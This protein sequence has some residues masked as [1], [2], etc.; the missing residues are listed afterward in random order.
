MTQALKRISAR[1]LTTLSTQELWD[2][3]TGKFVVVFDDGEITTNDRETIYS[4]YAWEFHRQ[5]PE[6]PMLMKH[7]VQTVLKGRRLSSGTNLTLIGNVLH[8]TYFHYV[9]NKIVPG[10]MDD[11]DF[12]DVLAKMAY[13]VS[14]EM[15]ND[16]SDYLMEYVTSTN[17]LDFLE[18]LDDPDIHAINEE[19]QKIT[20]TFAIQQPER[21]EELIVANYAVIDSVLSDA[22]RFALNPISKAYKSGLLNKG[23]VH[24]CLG[25]RGYMTDI[26]SKMFAVP[27]TR[28]YVQGIR[29]LYEHMMESRSAAKSHT[30]SKSPLQ[31]AEYFSRRLQLM[32]QLVQNLHRGDCGSQMYQRWLVRPA[33]KRGKKT[34]FPADLPNLLGKYYLDEESGKLKAIT[35]DDTHLEGK[36]IR[37]RT[38][39]GCAHP[40]PYGICSTCFGQLS[41]GIPRETNIGQLCCTSLAQKSS[42]IVLSIKHLDGSATVEVIELDYEEQKYLIAGP[43]GNTYILSPTLKGKKIKLY[44]RPE[45]AV[46]IGDVHYT[47]DIDARPASRFTEIDNVIFHIGEAKGYHAQELEVMLGRRLASLTHDMLKYAKKHGWE[48]DEHGNCIIDLSEWD[49]TKPIMQLPLRHFNMSDHQR[50]IAD[51]LETSVGRVKARGEADVKAEELIIELF[52]LVNSKLKVN[53]AILEVVLY[54]T[55]CADP[56]NN[57]YGLSKPWTKQEMVTLM[58]AMENRSLGA[59]LAFQKHRDILTSPYSCLITNRPDHPFDAFV[60]PQAVLEGE[61]A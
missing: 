21:T 35:M 41:F 19:V 14:N 23:Q 59:V 16:F 38:P 55:T 52:D 8:D 17:I 61:H 11:V 1:F 22:K 31:Q 45:Q 26:D 40:D 47:E 3:L 43:G 50:G 32:D 57:D 34:I 25:A 33:V 53:L 9:N 20:P 48:Y 30:F 10:A 49:F 56:A 36:Y 60:E 27:V 5:F 6:T 51:L 42:Q 28:G 7:H 12:M 29:K 4:S 37:L 18:I 2:S 15:Y 13:G 46:N 24:Q 58:T 54:A 44:L 39:L